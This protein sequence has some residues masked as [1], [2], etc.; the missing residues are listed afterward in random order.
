VGYKKKNF[1]RIP[2]S[3]FEFSNSFDRGKKMSKKRSNIQES[4]LCSRK[5]VAIRKVAF[6]NHSEF[7][8]KQSAALFQNCEKLLLKN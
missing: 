1:T 7:S 6:T 8:S 4:H 3:E 5:Q 2:P